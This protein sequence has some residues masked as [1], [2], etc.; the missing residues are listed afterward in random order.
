MSMKKFFL[1]I[2][3]QLVAGT[4]MTLGLIS[5]VYSVCKLFFPSKPYDF[6]W[7]C[8]GVLGFFVGYGLYKFALTYIHNEQDHYH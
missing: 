7:G 2:I 6:F 3:S 4:G 5:T 1:L 8:I